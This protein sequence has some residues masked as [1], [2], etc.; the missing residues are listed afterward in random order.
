MTLLNSQIEE[1]Q[2]IL[3]QLNHKVMLLN[4]KVMLKE[5][6]LG[7]SKIK[8]LKS[9]LDIAQ[10]QIKDLSQKIDEK[11]K[12]INELKEEIK[13]MRIKKGK[14]VE[15]KIESNINKID[16]IGLLLSNKNL[17]ETFNTINNTTF[18]TINNTPNLNVEE[19]NKLLKQ[20]ITR[21]KSALIELSKKLDKELIIK[22]QKN[23]KINE[24]NSKL[25]EELQKK[26]KDLAVKLKQEN[27]NSMILKKEKYDL[28]TIC[29]KQ[30]EV[31]RNLRKKINVSNSKIKNSGI[32][33]HNAY[34][35]GNILLRNY[36]IMGNM[37]TKTDGNPKNISINNNPLMLQNN[38]NA[39]NRSG[40]LP[41]IK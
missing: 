34:S 3:D 40:F 32:I 37:I 17:D 4:H 41:I 29:I 31:I 13:K 26:S 18:N 10:K 7:I 6:E 5:N 21:M 20:K 9:Q 14:F 12:V 33:K 15:L 11:N 28:E 22:E 24:S 16:I 38:I 30:E 23:L 35:K 39:H 8:E 19:E 25:F 2:Q 1:Q 27:M 36:H